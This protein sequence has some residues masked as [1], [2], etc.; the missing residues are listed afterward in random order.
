MKGAIRLVIAEMSGFGHC[1]LPRQGSIINLR[2]QGVSHPATQ[3][4][5]QLSDILQN[6]IKGSDACTC[7]WSQSGCKVRSS[8]WQTW[9][10]LSVIT[11]LIELQLWNLGINVCGWLWVSLKVRVELLFLCLLLKQTWTTSSMNSWK[12]VQVTTQRIF[13]VWLGC[14]W[15]SLLKMYPWSVIFDCLAALR[16]FYFITIIGT[17][18]GLIGWSSLERKNTLFKVD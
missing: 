14:P 1:F 10:Y 12:L 7:Y 13:G 4:W 5:W 16:V 9:R 8:S 17:I 11:H 3:L 6:T 15:L 2:L 18:G